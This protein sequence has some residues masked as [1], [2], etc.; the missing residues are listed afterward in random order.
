[1]RKRWQFLK[2]LN[3]SQH[4]RAL[5]QGKYSTYLQQ[6]L[7]LF[8]KQQIHITFYEN[9]VNNPEI[10]CR[11]IAR[12]AAINENYFS[13]FDFK[14]F[15]KTIPAGSVQAHRLFRKFKRSVRPVT[16]LFNVAIR[17]KIKLAAHHMENSYQIANRLEESEVASIS[18]KIKNFLNDYY[19]EDRDLLRKIINTTDPW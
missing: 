14:I 9:L 3:K 15:N 18:P 1:M 17:K 5:E 11:E 13:N 2:P 19:Y 4:L 8:G 12:F 16:R 10:F 6:Y 7:S